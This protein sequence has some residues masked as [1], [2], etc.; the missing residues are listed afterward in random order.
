MTSQA[1]TFKRRIYRWDYEEAA[2]IVM[3]TPE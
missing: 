3:K 1:P 2:E